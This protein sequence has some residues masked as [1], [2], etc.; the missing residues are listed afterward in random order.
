MKNETDGHSHRERAQRW[1]RIDSIAGSLT[2]RAVGMALQAIETTPEL[3]P[4]DATLLAAEHI[5]TW[6]PDLGS[7][8]SRVLMRVVTATG[9]YLNRFRPG[10]E[11]LYLGSELTYP[12]G[13]IDVAWRIPGVGVFFD[14]IKTSRH[15][16]VNPDDEEQLRRYGSFGRAE[17]GSDFLGIRY[18]P[19]LNPSRS[20]L[21]NLIGDALKLT[22]LADSPIHFTR[23][24]GRAA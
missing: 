8:H 7:H 24:P 10:N 12:G 18:L 23:D 9:V 14:E 15:V 13:R 1:N 21:A 5:S 16:G 22:P 19:L 2:H 3:D 4:F 11:A 6:Q 17:Y 20:L